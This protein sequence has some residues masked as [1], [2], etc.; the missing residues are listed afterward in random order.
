MPN[1]ATGPQMLIQRRVKAASVLIR[2]GCPLH[3]GRHLKA[4]ASTSCDRIQVI[5]S[6]GLQLVPSLSGL[7]NSK[8][9]VPAFAMGSYRSVLI[10]R[11][12][13]VNS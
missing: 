13:P 4:T 6:R 8:L 5:V 9:P 3:V 7:A 12:P 11:G 2:A 1:T 10:H